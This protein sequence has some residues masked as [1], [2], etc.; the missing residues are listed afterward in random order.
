MYIADQSIF[1]DY[2]TPT[3]FVKNV[4]LS[5]SDTPWCLFKK[6]EKLD[7]VRD[8]T[9]TYEGKTLRYGIIDEEAKTCKVIRSGEISGDLI[10]PAT[11]SDGKTNYTVTEIGKRAFA[12]CT[13]LTSVTIPNTVTSIG[14]FAFNDGMGLKKIVSLPSVSP[15][16]YDEDSRD[17]SYENLF[18]TVTL[19]IP[20]NGLPS[21]L[22]NRWSRFKNITI[23]GCALETYNDGE[24]IYR[25]DHVN[26]AACVVGNITNTVTI[27]ERITV[28]KDTPT[29]YQVTAIGYAAFAD[30]K[31]DSVFFT[32]RSQVTNIGD[33]AF[34]NCQR[35]YIV[36][37]IVLPST[38]ETIGEYA[39]CG[40]SSLQSINIPDKVTEIRNGTFKDCKWLNS[41]TLSDNI[42]SIGEKA[43]Y[44]A[45]R[46]GSLEIP[47]SLKHVDY[48]AFGPEK[49]GEIIIKDLRS[50]CNIEFMNEE[51]SPIYSGYASYKEFCTVKIKD[52]NGNLSILT[53]LVIPD[54]VTEIKPYAFAY[55]NSLKTVKI[56]S[57]VKIIGYEAFKYNSF[58]EL[59][60]PASVVEIGNGAFWNYGPFEKTE[61]VRSLISLTLEDGTEPISLFS[62]INS[63]HP[64]GK[65]TPENLYLG[66]PINDIES[67]FKTTLT[68]V[69]I[70]NLVD[71]IS[72]KLFR[73]CTSLKNLAFGGGVKTIG[74]EAFYNCKLS[75][76]ILPP[77]VEAI[78]EK[79]FADN[80][81]LSYIA[82]GEN[83]ISIGEKAFDGCPAD[84]IFIT[85]PTPPQAPNNVFSNYTGNLYVQGSEAIDAYY[86]AWTCWDR[87]EGKEMTVA[88][89]IEGESEDVSGMPGK[90]FKLTAT[91][92][93]QDVDL[94]YIFWHSTD[95]AVATVDTD[96]VV[97]LCDETNMEKSNSCKIIA[98]TLYAN[99]PRL[100]VSVTN[101]GISGIETVNCDNGTTT[102][103]GAPGIY[104]L[105][106]ICLSRE[107]TE[108][109]INRLSPGLYII[110]GKK[111]IIRK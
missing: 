28:E 5:P 42:L 21:Y 77:T 22:G 110:N 40:C 92:I 104:N 79:A 72:P 24:L 35:E 107:A 55:I 71:N 17:E 83:I 57:T 95:P 85:A 89:E 66:R 78:G 12:D 3:L 82:M 43:F 99:G 91:V 96:G 81:H 102:V 65:N 52:E 10:I 100:E 18:E 76:A 68:S 14:Y 64:F 109:E 6:V 20:S 32:S 25:L 19:E 86:D 108:D 2:Q 111:T 56:P 47:T 37:N 13:D 44:Y 98:E 39:F 26:K 87:F 94:P 15:Y 38:V 31:L 29:R 53:D 58:K 9:Y 33:Y 7:F 11:V 59:T 60:I 4:D 23:D 63:Y 34:Y 97:T 80:G 27:P 46:I 51:S 84:D 54:G 8:F 74:D 70:G 103:A 45:V 73:D 90:Q 50:W 62:T 75:K 48:D 41:I 106:G 101:E 93:P 69:T 16:L 61:Y 30:K 49:I 36:Y 105:Q 88:T 1:N 67:N